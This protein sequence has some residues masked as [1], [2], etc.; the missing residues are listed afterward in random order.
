[1]G[2]QEPVNAY[3]GRARRDALRVPDGLRDL[4]P[5]G[6]HQRRPSFEQLD[7]GVRTWISVD[8]DEPEPTRTMS[9]NGFDRSSTPTALLAIVDEEHETTETRFNVRPHFSV[10]R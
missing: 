3:R 1:M 5:L 9:T 2:E 6:R 10:L 4:K 7:L 8:H